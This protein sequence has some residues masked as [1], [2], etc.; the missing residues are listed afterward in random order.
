MFSRFREKK[1]PQKTPPINP[2][3]EGLLNNA[4]RIHHARQTTAVDAD[5]ASPQDQKLVAGPSASVSVETS[6][7]S[8]STSA[9]AIPRSGGRSWVS[10]PL[11]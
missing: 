3:K 2:N 9:Q 7:P 1:H 11:R 10:Q 4:M 5:S 8:P 6:S